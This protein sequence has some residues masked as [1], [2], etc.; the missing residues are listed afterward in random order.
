MKAIILAGG[1][2]T[3]L[4]PS[5]VAMSKQLLPVYDKPMI[6]YPLSSLML[7]GIRDVLIISTPD[8]IGHYEKLF[9]DGSHLGINISY[10]AQ[11]KPRGLADSFIIGEEFIGGDSV[12]LILGDNLFYGHSFIEKLK[13]STALKKGGIVFGYYVDNPQQ[14]GVLELGEN[15]MVLGVEEKPSK[16]KSN[17]AIP[18]IYF[19][20]N[21]CV[22]FAKNSE[23]SHRGELEITS[24]I[25]QY[26]DAGSLKTELLG[27]GITWLDTGTNDGLMDASIFVS[28]L[29][30][31]QGLKIACLEEVAYNMG[32]IDFAQLEKL[33]KNMR[34][35]SYSEYIKRIIFMH[36]NHNSP[37]HTS[38][39]EFSEIC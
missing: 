6:Y 32:F 25:Q 13:S 24:I 12:C 15:N 1:L 35:G 30:K 8:H 23:V 33:Y 28:V 26:I 22:E 38:I 9:Q 34:K 37:V 27:R 21:Q 16:P 31:R 2:G 7:A 11:D 36:K 39:K 29:E 4:Y 10:K 20:D 3:R 14:Y 19:F 17:Y 18:G 5:T